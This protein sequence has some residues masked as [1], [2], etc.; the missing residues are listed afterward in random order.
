MDQVS[1]FLLKII[2]PAHWRKRTS[3]FTDYMRVRA[4]TYEG[5]G[6]AAYK[7]KGPCCCRFL[8]CRLGDVLYRQE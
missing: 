7:R 1:R 8:Q 6:A 3:F 4:A 2:H 5:S